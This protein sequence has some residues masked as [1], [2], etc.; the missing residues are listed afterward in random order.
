MLSQKGTGFWA[1]LIRRAS[2]AIPPISQ[3]GCYVGSK[4]MHG[5]AIQHEE[6]CAPGVVE[7]QFTMVG[8]RLRAIQKHGQVLLMELDE[9]QGCRSDGYGQPIRL[10]G[11]LAYFKVLFSYLVEQNKLWSPKNSDLW[12][13]PGRERQMSEIKG[14]IFSPASSV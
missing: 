7:L 4:L 11:F 6:R 9:P 14:V 10:F 13:N 12:D 8:C 1:P 3:L 5:F 2:S